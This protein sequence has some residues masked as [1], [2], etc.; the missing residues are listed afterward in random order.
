MSWSSDAAIAGRDTGIPNFR[1]SSAIAAICGSA[2]T[3]PTL[4]P[5]SR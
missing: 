2:S 1:A 4:D 3:C 5:A